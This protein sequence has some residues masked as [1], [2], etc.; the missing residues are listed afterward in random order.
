[1]GKSIFMNILAIQ[2]FY[3]AFLLKYFVLL[4]TRREEIYRGTHINK[5]KLPHGNI[6]LLIDLGIL[7]IFKQF[8]VAIP[9]TPKVPLTL[10]WS[11]P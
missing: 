2:I 1:M 9:L 3:S 7:S 6:K 11:K 8:N 5:T 10:L 4:Y